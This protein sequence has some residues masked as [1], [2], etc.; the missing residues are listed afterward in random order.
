MNI[1]LEQTGEYVNG[2][3]EISMEMRSSEEQCAVHKYTEEADVK[4]PGGTA[5][6]R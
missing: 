6:Q 1:A 4:T 3:L 2:Q 5:L